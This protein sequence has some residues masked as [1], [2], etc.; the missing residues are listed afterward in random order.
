MSAHS[1]KPIFVLNGP[2]LHLLGAR[3]PEIYGTQTLADVESVCAKRAA[4]FGANIVFYQSNHEGALI[5][6]VHEAR[7][8][9]RAIVLNAG[10]FTHTSV[11]LHDAIKACEIPVIEC[12]LSNPAAREAF[13]HVSH[14]A[15]AAK[16]GVTGFGLMSYELAVEAAARLSAAR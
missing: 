10:A 5:D 4:Q 1:S 14:V 6:W 8:T 12:H 2:N 7:L 13:R 15:T 3:E 9:G 11:A 16:G